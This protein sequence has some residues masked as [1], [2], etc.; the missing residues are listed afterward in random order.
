MDFQEIRVNRF[1]NRFLFSSEKRDSFSVRVVY[2]LYKLYISKLTVYALIQ[3]LYVKSIFSLINKYL[4]L[5]LF[6]KIRTCFEIL[7]LT[8]SYVKRVYIENFS[9]TVRL[10]LQVLILEVLLY[11]RLVKALPPEQGSSS[12]LFYR[13][14]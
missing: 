13:R 10:K 2:H 1:L 9:L 3:M 5:T 6:D 11:A 8:G 12:A 14:Y 4:V 7:A